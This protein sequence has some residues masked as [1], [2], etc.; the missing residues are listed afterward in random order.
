[1]PITQAQAATAEQAQTLAA[2]EA[3]N[4]VRL[5]AGPGTGKSATIE[6]RV[7]H[8]LNN[9]AN[10]QRSFVVSFTRAACNELQDR[11]IR[12][13]ANQP[14]AGASTHVRVS[15][16]HSLALRILRSAAVLATLYPDDP[17]V[18]DDWEQENLYDIELA[19]SIGCTPSR[20]AEIRYA[21]DAQWQTLNHQSIAQAA[22]TNAEQQGFDTFH[23]ARRNLYSCVLPGEMVY[24]CVSRL[25]L[26]AIQIGQLPPIDHLIVDEFQDLNA[27]D[28]E[29]VSRLVSGGA[30]LF[31]AGDDDQSIY[32]FRHAN[33]D[34]IIN[35]AAT[36]QNAITHSLTACFRCTPAVLQPALNLIA[37]NPGR[38][39]K[40]L[41]SLYSTSN[42]PVQG[43]TQV[44]SFQS[45]QIEANAVAE[46]CQHLIQNGMAGQEDQI[47]ILIFSRRLQLANI[48]RELGNLGLPY[49][50]PAGE[51]LRDEAAF[52]A[53]YT[54]LR[55]LSDI[56]TPSRDYVA[57]RS[58]LGQLHGV[59]ANTAKGVGDLCIANNQ[60]Y[61]GLFQ[62]TPVP[63]WLLGRTA[64][65]VTRVQAILQLVTGWTPQDTLGTRTNDIATI[66][67]NLVFSGSAQNAAYLNE[68]NTL[69]ASLPQNM[70]LDELRAFF[71]ADEIGQRHILDD[72]K[73]RFEQNEADESGPQQKRI[74]I[75]TMHGA[76]GLSGKVVFIPSA[77]QGLMPS[78]RAI[79]AAGLLIEQRRLF[80]VSLTRA[81]ACCIV[82]HSSLH[83]GAEA[84]AIRQQPQVRL[85]RSQ[86]LNEMGA[87]SVNR[88]RGLTAAEA[89][90]VIAHVNEL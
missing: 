50:P 31:V 72:I 57:Y 84:Y 37:Y 87:P 15:T 85:P 23:A 79:Q 1:M 88:N 64:V 52:R 74:R 63:H 8:L 78:F 39:P 43:T 86:F 70:T 6:R 49:D 12:H 30:N 29:F 76:K 28:Q 65:A 9:G 21:H 58:L 44:W 32:S 26:G 2:I 14:C 34:G 60:N 25:Q 35:F 40:Q 5:V 19:S 56:N 77:E 66:L 22:I 41:V 59:G 54:I 45:S 17:V 81:K 53:V 67:A 46:S 16:M 55:L 36:Y 73:K 18:L 68:W 62:L 80:Y 89:T 83:V 48:T 75:L 38:L 51:S 27:C 90:A 42:P 7:A 24:E 20:A 33:P 82:S 11:I 13:C 71:G 3:A 69:S 61:R 47:V 4:R 10:P